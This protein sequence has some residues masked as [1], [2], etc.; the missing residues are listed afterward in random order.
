MPKSDSVCEQLKKTAER[1]AE[2]YGHSVGVAVREILAVF[3]PGVPRLGEV[4]SVYCDMEFALVTEEQIAGID[5]EVNEWQPDIEQI[6]E[7]MDL[8]RHDD[9]HQLLLRVCSLVTSGANFGRNIDECCDLILRT[10]ANRLAVN[11]EVGLRKLHADISGLQGEMQLVKLLLNALTRSFSLLLELPTDGL[12]NVFH[13]IIGLLL[14]PEPYPLPEKHDVRAYALLT[15]ARAR[16]ARFLRE[17]QDVELQAQCLEEAAASISAFHQLSPSANLMRGVA[18]ALKSCRLEDLK[19]LALLLRQ[20]PLLPQSTSELVADF[21]TA[22]CDLLYDKAMALESTEPDQAKKLYAYAAE[23]NAEQIRLRQEA[24]ARRKQFEELY[25]QGKELAESDPSKALELLIQA[26]SV[27]P[28]FC[29]QDF[30]QYLR[31]VEERAAKRLSFEKLYTQG[32]ELAE[33]DPSK[34]LELLIQAQSI[35]PEFCDQDFQQYLSYVEERAAKKLSF[36]ELYTRGKELA[37]S[38]PIGA[39][40]LLQ[41]AQ[42]VAPEFCD[43]DFQ[44]Y[45]RYV[46][47]R[48]AKKLYFEKLYTQGKELAESDP[49]KA[50][51]LLQQAQSVAPEFCDKDFQQYMGYVEERAAKKLSFEKLHTRGKELAE[52]DPSKALD[53]LQQA[54][55]VEPELCDRDVA[56]VTADCFAI[57][58]DKLQ[59][60]RNIYR[61][62]WLPKRVECGGCRFVLPKEAMEGGYLV[63]LPPLPNGLERKV[64]LARDNSPLLEMVKIPAGIARLGDPK[65]KVYVGEYW[66][67]RTPVTNRMWQKFLQES[68][69]QPAGADNDKT[70]GDYLDH[71]KKNSPPSDQLDHP[72][73][74]V[75][76][77]NVWAF[78]DFYGLVLPSE[79]QWEKAARGVDG[80]TYSWG[81]AQPTSELCNFHGSGINTTTP[82]GQYERGMSPFGLLD[83]SGNVWE[84]C[85]DLYQNDWLEQISKNEQN[86]YI[87]CLSKNRVSGYI[88]LRGGSFFRRTEIVRC[89]F[90]NRFT[91]GICFDFIGFRPS[92]DVGL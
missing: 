6:Y 16:G 10:I 91:A 63:K 38:D 70:Y 28:E 47:E 57:S 78:C 83:C 55:Y 7:V 85:A 31:Y 9:M 17:S 52:S 8:L 23:I 75:S 68:G 48:I 66:I 67:A 54:Q 92:Q 24:A 34:A 73:V 44:Q 2:K 32:K 12:P 49:S 19:N 77:I 87:I 42:S 26:Q 43:Q 41:Q 90:R 88:A 50:L 30:Q 21:T 40:E 36:E 5:V 81:E 39:L 76:Y 59:P 20:T 4:L 61:P 72:V 69:Y 18:I 46:E 15:K 65:K 58:F 25:K 86:G 53:L 35:A 45:L 64:I 84:W 56:D 71:W 14:Q 3:M 60:R 29:D 89:A 33:S 51:E 74:Y 82:V 1:F 27:A 62:E 13:N 79:A 11:R 22:T 80:R 37:E